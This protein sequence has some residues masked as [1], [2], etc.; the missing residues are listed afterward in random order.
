M[1]DLTAGATERG[2]KRD[3]P[4]PGAESGLANARGDRRLE[5]PGKELLEAVEAKAGI[6]DLDLQE[7][8]R[9]LA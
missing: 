2:A 1:T 9:E 5:I 7:Q 4:W 8:L 3:M 6:A